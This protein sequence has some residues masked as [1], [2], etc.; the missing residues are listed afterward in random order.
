MSNMDGKGRKQTDPDRTLASASYR[1]LYS[2]CRCRIK[3]PASRR[4]VDSP[5]LCGAQLYKRSHNSAKT[6]SGAATCKTAKRS[7]SVED[8]ENR[9]HSNFVDEHESSESHR[10]KRGA[11]TYIDQVRRRRTTFGKRRKGIVK[12]AYELSLLTGSQVLVIVAG[13][14]RCVYTFAT[15][16]LK[17]VIAECLKAYTGEP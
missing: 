4:L 16:K 11:L 9:D 3:A 12:K 14:S 5:R 8:K 15:Q 1:H 7:S 6:H 17:P 13:E 2:G 10:K